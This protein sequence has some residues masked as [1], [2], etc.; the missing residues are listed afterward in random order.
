LF[1]LAMADMSKSPEDETYSAAKLCH[2]PKPS[3]DWT[4]QF[5]SLPSLAE[6]QAAMIRKE[7]EAL[8]AS[9]VKQFEAMTDAEME[10]N[11]R[12]EKRAQRR[13]ERKSRAL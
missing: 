8:S 6:Q 5:D 1:I 12:E 11:E 2:V 3:Q 9:P 10:E 13:R 7:A 4:Y